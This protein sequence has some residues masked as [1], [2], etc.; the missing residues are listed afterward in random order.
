[1][2]DTFLWDNES[3]NR[4]H[5][6]ENPSVSIDNIASAI[7]NSHTSTTNARREGVPRYASKGVKLGLVV[8]A[9]SVAVVLGVVVIRNG[10]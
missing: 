3:P 10:S 2:A 4:A 8:L 1:M 6:V 5:D 7:S 9:V